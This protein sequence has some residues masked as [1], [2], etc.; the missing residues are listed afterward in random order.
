MI[1]AL[2][3]LPLV[4]LLAIAACN[5]DPT[6]T[7]TAGGATAPT[8]TA[9]PRPATLSEVLDT[10][11]LALAD[12]DSLSFDLVVA[13]PSRTDIEV[14][15]AW[16]AP[17]RYRLTASIR[18]C[19][20]PVPGAS[21]PAQCD[22]ITVYKAVAI[23][24]TL[25]ATPGDDYWEVASTDEFSGIKLMADTGSP[26]SR[27]LDAVDAADASAAMTEATLDGENVYH[28]TTQDGT[29]AYDLYVSR[30]TRLPMRAIVTV[31]GAGGS[32]WTWTFAGYD[33]P[34]TIE[35]PTVQAPP[36]N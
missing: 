1:R 6:P 15:G 32:T 5:A 33:S 17:D 2:Y 25:Y 21:A 9:T 31:P 34:I 35:A 20:P 13:R 29:A 26:S 23:G 30:T 22:P 7:P 36:S 3:L 27:I 28:V 24:S 10:A 18:I 11:R 16:A 8:P 12:M 4:A 19:P 14:A